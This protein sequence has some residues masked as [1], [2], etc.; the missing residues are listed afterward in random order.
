MSEIHD[1]VDK[2]NICI[3]NIG[4]SNYKIPFTLVNEKKEYITIAEVTSGVKLNA[5]TKGAH[6]S[7]IITTIDST[8]ANKK[9]TILDLQKSVF[10][11]EKE[12]GLDNANIMLDFTIIFQAK[13]PISNYVT[14]LNSKITLF[15]ES[16]NGIILNEYMKIRGNGAMLCPNSKAKSKY[17]AHSQK[18]DISLTLYS[19]FYDINIEEYYDMI[20]NASSAPVFGVVRSVDEV[21]LTELAYENPKFSEDAIRDLL[22]KTRKKHPVGKISV[23][24][25]NY[26]SIHQ[27]NVFCEGTIE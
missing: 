18:C 14:N 8:L 3:D 10:D 11:L 22:I 21:Y 12:I 1:T 27:H 25:K 7:R 5:E 16:K 19:D 6:L 24:L 23:D 9:L 26:E 2:R 13:T 17:G 4:I 15:F 20:C